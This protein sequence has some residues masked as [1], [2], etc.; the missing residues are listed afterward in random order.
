[1]L[2]A[3]GGMILNI[4]EVTLVAIILVGIARL[5]AHN[6]QYFRDYSLLL[7]PLLYIAIFLVIVLPGFFTVF[8]MSKLAGRFR[9][10]GAIILAVTGSLIWLSFSAMILMRHGKPNNWTI[11]LGFISNILGQLWAAIIIIRGRS[12][13]DLLAVSIN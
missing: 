8:L 5:S 13:K 10:L 12:K 4:V 6:S 11:L 1:L 7:I 2:L 3:V 9:T